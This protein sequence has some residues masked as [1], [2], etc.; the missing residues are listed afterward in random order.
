MRVYSAGATGNTY[1]LMVLL[2]LQL[3]RHMLIALVGIVFSVINPLVP[4]VS[5]IYFAG[6][7][8]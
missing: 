6:E 1:V 8:F 3:P 4:I 2:F 7:S 5:I